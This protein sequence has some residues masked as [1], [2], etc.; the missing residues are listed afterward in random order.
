MLS[1]PP[2]EFDWPKP[3]EPISAESRC[4]EFPRIMGEVFG[5]YETAPSL[6]AELQ[7]ECCP[8]H[9]LHGRSCMAVAA[10]RDDPNEFVFLTDHPAFPIAFVHLTWSVEKD[11][12]FPYTVGYAS[13][14]AFEMAWRQSAGLT[15]R[16]SGPAY[17]RAADLWALDAS[18]L[19]RRCMH[20]ASSP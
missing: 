8:A 3:W 18:G 11:P 10:A 7:R 14:K 9:P 15:W 16:C 5:D 6:S 1:H 19:R 4:L 2:P 12:M 17:R 20:E 13:W